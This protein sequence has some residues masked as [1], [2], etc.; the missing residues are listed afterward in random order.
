M[1]RRTRRVPAGYPP[2]RSSDPQ[3][4]DRMRPG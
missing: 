2:R 4:H 3:Q 1:A